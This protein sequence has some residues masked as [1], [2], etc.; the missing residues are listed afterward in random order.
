MD[1]VELQNGSERWFFGRGFGL[2]AWSSAWGESA[3]SQV[4]AP[5]ERPALV[6][7]QIKCSY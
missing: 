7:E 3:I 4:Y 2:C 5:G 1:V 6:R